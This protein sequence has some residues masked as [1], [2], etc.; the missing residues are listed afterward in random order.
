MGGGERYVFDD[1]Y[2]A[3]T[4]YELEANNNYDNTSIIVDNIPQNL[5]NLD[6]PSPNYS[7]RSLYLFWC[8]SEN[9]FAGGL[10]GKLY[11]TQLQVDN[12]VVRDFI[13]V[14]NN[15]IGKYGMFD[16]ISGQFFGNSGSGDFGGGN[17]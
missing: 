6:N 1:F 14:F 2:D 3:D 10:I 13:P 4:V 11:R 7:V 9:T 8:H 16:N 15:K 12:V 17:D 5:E